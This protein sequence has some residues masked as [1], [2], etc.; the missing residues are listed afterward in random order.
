M[1]NRR[2]VLIFVLLLSEALSQGL[3]PVFYDGFD[4][5][6]LDTKHWTHGILGHYNGNPCN[7]LHGQRFGART[8]TVPENNVVSGG[9]L[10]ITTKYEPG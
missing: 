5:T 2:I 10:R 4:G 8:V 9:K 7:T 6:S 1:K 3:I